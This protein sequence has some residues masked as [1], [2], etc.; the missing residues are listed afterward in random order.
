VVTKKLTQEEYFADRLAEAVSVITA[1]GPLGIHQA[2]LQRELQIGDVLLGRVFR[3]LREPE[4]KIHVASWRLCGKNP[5]PAFAMG[6]SE[7]VPKPAR[8]S[9]R[10]T[11]RHDPPNA[12]QLA[13]RDAA[14]VHE[15]W[16]ATWRP[17]CD[18]AAQWFHG[19][20]A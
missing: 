12:A 1:A 2:A 16:K 17:H 9:R 13:A 5:R 10:A 6:D 3:A 20:A 19:N 14:R 15:A 8:D 11:I 7:D 4:R 18:A